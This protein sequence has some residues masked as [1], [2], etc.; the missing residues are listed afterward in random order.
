MPGFRM[1]QAFVRV[2]EPVRRDARFAAVVQHDEPVIAIGTV[3]EIPRYFSRADADPEPAATVDVRIVR[4]GQ[5]A[6]AIAREQAVQ[7]TVGM[8]PVNAAVFGAEM[9]Q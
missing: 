3:A 5:G 7:P 6:R 8:Q 4:G 9:G 1:D 2:A